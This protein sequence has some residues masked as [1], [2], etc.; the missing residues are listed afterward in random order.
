MAT[1]EE[2]Y[3]SINR[4]EYKKG[5]SN[6]LASQIDLLNSVKHL[7]NLNQFLQQEKNLKTRMHELFDSIKEDME[8]L[9]D[10]IPTAAIPKSVK[11][12]HPHKPKAP[13]KPPT[14][15]SIIEEPGEP[16]SVDLEL[17]GIQEKLKQLNA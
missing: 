15:I 7:R 9:E 14:E 16:D 1:K 17:Q 11:I 5:K 13:E 6:I 3:M 10:S 2:I 8:I 4:E 12:N